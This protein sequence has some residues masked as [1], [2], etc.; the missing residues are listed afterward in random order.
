ML[1]NE[2]F[3]M[4]EEEEQIDFLFQEIFDALED[5]GDKVEGLD[6]DLREIALMLNDDIN[7]SVAKTSSELKR[8]KKSAL[9]NK[10]ELIKKIGRGEYNK[11]L[12]KAAKYRKKNKNKLKKQRTK[13]AKS[14]AGKKAK[15][16]AS[17][18]K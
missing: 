7:E 4:F 8:K 15:R 10:K 11:R 13:Y 18:R 1:F 12:K 17:K 16:I 3:K 9:K 14:S 6:E 2:A 5:C